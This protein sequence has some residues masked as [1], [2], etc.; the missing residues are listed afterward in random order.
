MTLKTQKFP[1]KQK[2]KN[3]T[4]FA[5]K[6]LKNILTYFKKLS[7]KMYQFWSKKWLILQDFGNIL[8]K[9]FNLF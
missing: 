1:Q 6:F 4:F 3:L 5:E 2:K 7:G 8:E 9:Y